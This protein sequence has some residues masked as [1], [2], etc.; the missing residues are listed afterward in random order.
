MYLSFRERLNNTVTERYKM[1]CDISYNLKFKI[2]IPFRVL[3]NLNV[4]IYFLKRNIKYRQSMLLLNYDIRNIRN[5]ENCYDLFL[6]F[7]PGS[8]GRQESLSRRDF[9]SF[10]PLI[11]ATRGEN[12]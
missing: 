3:A 12:E 9:H 5:S 8:D 7:M 4:Q 6:P 2:V 10:S 1:R 11:A